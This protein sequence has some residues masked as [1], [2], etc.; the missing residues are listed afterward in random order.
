MAKILVASEDLLAQEQMV[1]TIEAEGYQVITAMDGYEAQ[2]VALAEQPDLVLLEPKLAVFNG[3]ETALALREDP[4]IS[5]EV[6]I[7]MITD[8]TVDPHKVERYRIT[9]LF[10]KTH[11]S[12]HLRDMVIR[13]LGDKAGI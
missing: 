3:F 8:E 1:A 6:P 5:D 9:E 4:E 13:L 10:P 7:V 12:V 2:E 11:G